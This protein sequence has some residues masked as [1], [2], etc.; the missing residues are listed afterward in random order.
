MND[1][2]RM[3]GQAF[4]ED[5]SS[6][7]SPDG[8]A[9]LQAQLDAANARAEENYNKYLYAIAD[10]ENYKKRI[11]RQFRE[12][13][14]SGRREL[15]RSLLPVIDNLERSLKFENGSDGLRTGIEHTL[16]GFEG[17]LATQGVKPIEVKGKRFDPNVAEAIDALPAE[18]VEDDTILEEAQKGYRL[19]EEI[20]RPAKVIVSK[21]S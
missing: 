17:V 15:L 9:A 4:T 3:M 14:E 6:V 2:D 8:P 19:G 18:G 1:D 7:E 13:A 5:P 16:K 21:S 10:F 11:E 12:I 20:L